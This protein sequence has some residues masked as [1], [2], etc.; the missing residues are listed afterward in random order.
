[1]K[2]NIYRPNTL[3]PTARRMLEDQRVSVIVESFHG[4]DWHKQT[5]AFPNFSVCQNPKD[6]PG[7]FTVRLFDGQQPTRL[8]AVKGTLE[9]ARATIPNIF[10]R[11]PRSSTD[12]PVIVETWL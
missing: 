11:V 1:M 9:E 7:K 2:T 6:F 10:Y 4:V 8:V 5:K 3:N 12:N